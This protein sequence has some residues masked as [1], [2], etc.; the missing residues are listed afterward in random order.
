MTDLFGNFPNITWIDVETGGLE[1]STDKLFEVAA[2]VTDRNLNILDPLGFNMVI[3]YPEEEVEAIRNASVP[4][5]QD[6]HDKTGLW[7][8][9][10]SGTPRLEVDEKLH[11]YISQFSEP[12]TSWIGGNSITLDRNF[13]RA[14]LP[15]SF[16]HLS[17]RSIDVSTLGGLSRAWF[18]ISYEK[19]KYLHSAFSDI[20]ESIEE[21]RFYR[22]SIFKAVPHK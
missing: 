20:T 9:L 13:L 4:F 22:E 11:E 8:R 12:K 19:K 15:Q 1:E 14:N 3:Q 17:Y 7:D 6:M 2:I 18:G 16:S 21:L 10:P 5:V